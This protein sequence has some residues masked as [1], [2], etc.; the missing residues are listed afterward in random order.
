MRPLVRAARCLPL[1]VALLVAPV[2]AAAKPLDRDAAAQ[3]PRLTRKVSLRSHRISVGELCR[4]LSRQSG[5]SIQ[6][7]SDRDGAGDELVSL[8]LRSVSLH[9]ALNAIWSLFSYRDAEWLW[10]RTGTGDESRYRL[11]RPLA[12]QQLP[13]RLQAWSQEQFERQAARLIAAALAAP[14]ERARLAEQDPI[15]RSALDDPQFWKALRLFHLLLPPDQRLKVLRGEA[16]IRLPVTGLPQE[17]REFAL[18]EF[19]KAGRMGRFGGMIGAAGPE[20]IEFGASPDSEP[21]TYS[22]SLFVY[23]QGLGGFSYAGGTPLRSD[24]L[25]HFQESWLLPGDSPDTEMEASRVGPGAREKP[26]PS[27]EDPRLD[28]RL[29]ELSAAAPLSFIAQLPPTQELR[30]PGSPSGGVLSAFLKRVADRRPQLLHKWRDGVLLCTYPSWHN[31]LRRAGVLPWKAREAFLALPHSPSSLLTLRDLSRIAAETTAPQFEALAE[32]LPNLRG[33]EHWRALLLL[34]RTQPNLW[35]RLGS[36][37]GIPTALLRTLPPVS[38]PPIL[39][40][41]IG[42]AAALRLSLQ[43]STSNEREEILQLEQLD[44]RGRA[45]SARSIILRADR[46]E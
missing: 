15:I 41:Q 10:S 16:R 30:D 5:V 37:E 42:S 12:A 33:A 8:D 45:T 13:G 24:F 43:P 2:A 11:Y 31:P 21:D 29:F 25:R 3:D 4:E 26:F 36:R 23:L 39:A 28:Q 14:E 19:E 9:A 22:R 40:E 34:A 17:G 6:V 1:A 27:R 20:W 46:P 38:V 7:G 44:E 35:K 18:E 32:D